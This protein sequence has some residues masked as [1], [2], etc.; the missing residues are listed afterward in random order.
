MAK[1]DRNRVNRAEDRINMAITFN[2]ENGVPA[3]TRDVSASGIYFETDANQVPGS[4]IS[5]V[6]RFNTPG[7][8]MALKCEGQILRTE[9]RG[10]RVGIAAKL[11]TTKVEVCH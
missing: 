2:L 10:D 4:M 11:T 9:P 6:L 1:K 3:L 8:E 5:F 7:G